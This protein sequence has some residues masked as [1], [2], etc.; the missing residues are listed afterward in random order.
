[1]ERLNKI[2]KY[3]LNVIRKGFSNIECLALGFLL[4]TNDVP[5]EDVYLFLQSGY[6]RS[7]LEEH[8]NIRE[9]S[10]EIKYFYEGF[11]RNK[12]QVIEEILNS[13][14]P[15]KFKEYPISFF[16]ILFIIK[17]L[18]PERFRECVEQMIDYLGYKE[19]LEKQPTQ[20]LIQSLSQISNTNPLLVIMGEDPLIKITGILKKKGK[21]VRV[22]SLGEGQIESA[23]LAL[24]EIDKVD[25]LILHN[26]H[27]S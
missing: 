25:V 17:L 8:I 15:Y 5:R 1:M 11:S 27:L 6:P 3:I 14:N 22:V 19:L 20:D 21:T 13:P 7:T 9:A 24:E 26:L 12:D 23:E 4:C 16:S 2:K 10:D 18:K